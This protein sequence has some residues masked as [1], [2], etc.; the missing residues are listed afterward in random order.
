MAVYRNLIVASAA[1][2]GPSV[3]VPVHGAVEL[4]QSY[5]EL[6]AQTLYRYAGG[7]AAVRRQWSGKLRTEVSGK[8]LVPA[9]LQALCSATGAVTISCAALRSVRS[10][11]STVTIPSA[12]RDDLTII[13]KSGASVTGQSWYCRVWDGDVYATASGSTT[14]G[15]DDTII[16]T[17]ASG[18]SHGGYEVIYAPEFT[19]YAELTESWMQNDGWTWQLV[20][21]EA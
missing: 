7:G 3:T 2:G 19:G 11:S 8:G 12:R 5:A 20:V 4:T 13:N 17:L 10:N 16:F 6:R 1:S 9:G 21:E 18:E 15:S 14:S